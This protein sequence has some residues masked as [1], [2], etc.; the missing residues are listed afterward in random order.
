MNPPTAL[1]AGTPPPQDNAPRRPAWGLLVY[2]AGDTEE[3]GE[4][5]RDDLGEILK[6]GGSSDLRIVVQYD[7]TEG[8]LRHIV[9]S[10]TSCAPTVRQLGRVDS[11]STA[12]LLDFLQ[13]GISVCDSERLALVLGS[14]LV[15]SPGDA[16]RD[17]DRISV[18]SLTHDAGSG[19]YLD[20]CDMA[21]T[22]REA[23]KDSG[24]DQLDLLAIDSCRVQFL[25]LAYELEDIVRILIAPQT[26][27]PAAGWDYIRILTK[28]KEQAAFREHASTRDVATAL[29]DDISDCYRD[30]AKLRSV[31][32]LDL[33]RLDDVANAFDTMCIGTLQALGEGLIWETRKLLLAALA[34]SASRSDAPTD[35]S[36][37]SDPSRKNGDVPVYDC[38]SFFAMWSSALK[39]MSAEA[40]QGW[41]GK[42][43]ERA[44][45]TKL[46]RFCEAVARQLESA[47]ANSARP[48][49][50]TEGR[51]VTD[52]LRLLVTALRAKPRTAPARD[53]L[54]AVGFAV[55]N[56]VTLLEPGASAEA[57]SR[58]ASA[59]AARGPP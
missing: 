24:R 40:Y 53:F 16:E 52:R 48:D 55:S 57:A 56:Q 26:E 8:A 45:G 37:E 18:F 22:V 27:I 30:G 41:L 13:W 6:A 21:G 25:E 51:L 20:V 36:S 49:V 23:L 33:Q 47:L 11:G 50:A 58:E 3:W 1:D 19:N 29:L 54:H 43:V 34:K 7:G 35:E 17:P 14:P 44:N 12:A 5:L 2:L 39:A 32:A 31:S 4:A 38:G 15:V 42:T 28:W 59:A 10:G 46:D 9:S